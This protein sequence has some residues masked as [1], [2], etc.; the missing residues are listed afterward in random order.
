[1]DRGRKESV[2]ESWCCP[3]EVVVP[4]TA[5]IDDSDDD[6]DGCGS[7]VDGTSQDSAG[8]QELEEEASDV[9]FWRS[10]ETA[11][12]RRRFL[13]PPNTSRPTTVAYRGYVHAGDDCSDDDG[14]SDPEVAA[15]RRQEED[16]KFWEACLAS[17]Y[18]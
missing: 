15:A 13:W 3:T 9:A 16:R 8:L 6:D 12:S 1:M 4:D 5:A 17:G 18:P 11:S 14:D 7:C 10:Q 2:A